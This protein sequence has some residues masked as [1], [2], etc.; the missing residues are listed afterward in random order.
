MPDYYGA[1]IAHGYASAGEDI[2]KGITAAYLQHKK[3]Q[4]DAEGVQGLLDIA[5]RMQVPDPKTG[6]PTQ[7]F[8]DEQLQYVQRLIDQKKFK[9]AGAA[10]AALG[11]GRDMNMRIQTAAAKQQAALQK[12]QQEQAAMQQGPITA[13]DP[14]GRRYLYNQH[15]KTYQTDTAV[16]RD[17]SGQTTE[18]QQ[19]FQKA[20]LSQQAAQQN[21]QRTGFNVLLKSM[22]LSP[23]SLFDTTK[24]MPGT[25]VPG[26]GFLPTA[27]FMPTKDKGQ[28]ADPATTPPDTTHISIGYRPPATDD[29]GRL[30]VDK[31]GKPIDPGD[32]GRVLSIQE[33]NALRDAQAQLAGPEASNAWKWM[34]TSPDTTQTDFN[35]NP[36]TPDSIDQYNKL[37][38][39]VEKRFHEDIAKGFEL[40]KQ[41]I[42]TTTAPPAAPAAAF[43]QG[44]VPVV[45]TNPLPDTPP[46]TDTTDSEV[47]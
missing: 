28:L 32:Q 37:K 13:T 17:A 24:H 29:K 46:P 47:E 19:N 44:A 1:S 23:Q 14:S 16:P 18:E 3:Q 41:E 33:F 10:E 35:G 39:Q 2:A 22:N 45:P 6:K 43:P 7:F 4:A 36:W 40:P 5:S 21:V 38:P 8:K 15:T 34:N 20:M 9:A 31:R 11:I 12:A 27:D 30:K 42:T 25:V 26:R